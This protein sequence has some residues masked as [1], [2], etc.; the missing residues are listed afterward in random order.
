LVTSD[1]AFYQN[2]KYVNGLAKNLLDEVSNAPHRLQIFCSLPDL[3]KELRRD[4]LI[5][6]DALV[7]RFLDEHKASVDGTLSRN[8]FALGDRIGVAKTLYA[9]E[10]PDTLYLTFELE[11][12]V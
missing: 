7:A 8:G 3:L 10:R 5:D 2:R 12:H 4:V 11:I 1:S 6:V 9:T